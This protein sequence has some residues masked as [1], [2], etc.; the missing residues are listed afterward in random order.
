M[1]EVQRWYTSAMFQ[2][3]ALGLLAFIAVT[4]GVVAIGFRDGD[5]EWHCKYGEYFLEGQENRD[6]Y[7]PARGVMDVPLALMPYRVAR[8][9][10][11]VL[12]L[13]AL[14]MCWRIWSE[15]GDLSAKVSP[16]IALAAG[17]LTVG[18]MLPY[19]LRELDECGLQIFLLTLLTFGGWALMRG[20]AWQAGFFLA[21]AASY[22]AVPVIVLPFLLWKRQWRAA[23]WMTVFLFAWAATPALF[24]GWSHNVRAH[25]RWIAESRRLKEAKQAYPSLLDREPQLIYNLSLYALIARNLETYPPGH[26]LYVDHPYFFQPGTLQPVEA[27]YVM[28]G[29]LA[30]IAV[31]FLIRTRRSWTSVSVGK[32][33]PAEWAAVCAFCTLMSPLCWKQHFIVVL[34]CA[35]LVWRR[36]LSETTPKHWHWA[37]LSLVS[38]IAYAGRRS[39]VGDF[40]D[41]MLSYKFDTIGMLTLQFWTLTPSSP[42]VGVASTEND[43]SASREESRPMAA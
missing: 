43:A 12:C 34:P 7:P 42:A 30:V 27:Y 33:L 32:L 13:A 39:I 31:A 36:V 17:I 15:M 9:V 23:G 3:F 35:F 26:S 29:I 41:V 19:L 14:V 38:L 1:V 28:H 5:F 16:R 40:S 25:E 6:H 20:R 22:K 4:Q 11:Y 8:A 18:T 21:T 24:H 37:V 10:S 2:K